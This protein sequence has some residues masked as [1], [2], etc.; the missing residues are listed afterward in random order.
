MITEIGVKFLINEQ[1][2][3][4][5]HQIYNSLRQQIEKKFPLGNNLLVNMTWFGPQFNNP[6]W[7][8][9]N[10]LINKNKSFDRIFWIDIIDPV[11][12][13]PD[14]ISDLENKL[15]VKEKY[16][17]GTAFTGKYSFNTASIVCYEDFPAYLES[18]LSLTNVEFL[19]LNYN[20]KPKPHRI[21][22]VELLHEHNLEKHGIITLGKN[23]A[24]YDVSQGKTTTFHLT[25][26]DA[27]DGTHGGKFPKQTTFGDFGGVPYDL[28]SLGNINI[29][30][31]HFLNIVSE[32]EFLPWDTVFVTE[33]TLKPIIGLRPFVINGQ[34]TV[35]QWLRDCGFKTFNHYFNG[36]ELEDIKEFEV[37]DAIIN[38]VKYLVTLDQ[39][40]ISAMYNDMLPDLKH[41]RARFFE[42][43]QEQKYK[44]EHL[45]E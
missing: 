12:L 3:R 10:Q 28:C 14:Q 31:N 21:R 44:I 25:V 43:A 30:Q 1:F 23:D 9:I 33:K 36:I 2:G 24:A 27:I 42:F 4:Q 40:E 6:T 38:V 29:W 26:N 32:T 19:Y 8:S 11:T 34:T 13:L 41:N 17:I 37:H 22:M 20:R 7:P 5:E 18:D 16:Y 45:F 35:Y 39:T 15:Q